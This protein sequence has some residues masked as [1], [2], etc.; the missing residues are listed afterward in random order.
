MAKA[1][2]DASKSVAKTAPARKRNSTTS[3]SS[4]TPKRQPF[5]QNKSIVCYSCQQTGHIAPQC[6][7]RSASAA[8]ASTSTSSTP[9]PVKK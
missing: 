9:K 3:A 6:P 7:S 4:M 2:A 8:P 5:R 1:M